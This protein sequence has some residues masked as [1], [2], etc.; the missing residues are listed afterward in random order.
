MRDLIPSF[1]CPTTFCGPTMSTLLPS[2]DMRWMIKLMSLILAF[3]AALDL[4]S[5]LLEATSEVVEH[6]VE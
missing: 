6:R 2:R 3:A 5:V 4:R 1:L